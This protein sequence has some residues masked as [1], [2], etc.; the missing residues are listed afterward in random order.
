MSYHRQLE[1]SHRHPFRRGPHRRAGRCLQGRRHQQPLLVTDAG[2]A[3]LPITRAALDRCSKE[4]GFRR[5]R[6][7]PTCSRTRWRPT[8][9]AG[10]DVFRAGKHDGVVAFGGGSASMSA[11]SSPSWRGRPGR[12]GISRTSATGGRAPIADKISPI[13][14]VPTTAGTGSEVGRAGVIT[15]ETTHTKKI[16]FHPEDDA[17]GRHLPI[18]S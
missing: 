16:I 17:E 9:N 14:A 15:D 12:C 5:R 11:S 1:L 2:L 6:C 13:V 18:R 8:S 7:S 10:I 3:K 4:A